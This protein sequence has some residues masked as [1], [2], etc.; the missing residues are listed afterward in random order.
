MSF[1]TSCH[2]RLHVISNFMS[3]QISCHLRFHVISDFMPFEI[4]CHLDLRLL[5]NTIEW[6][7]TL[8]IS[9]GWGGYLRLLIK[10]SGTSANAQRA[11]EAFTSSTW[12]TWKGT[13]MLNEKLLRRGTAVVWSRERFKK[14]LWVP[15]DTLFTGTPASRVWCDG[16]KWHLQIWTL[17]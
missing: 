8:N 16:L 12:A 11:W 17:R 1:Q 6:F 14:L 3:F 7:R 2:F 9:G 4:S 5:H 10:R 13:T 15:P